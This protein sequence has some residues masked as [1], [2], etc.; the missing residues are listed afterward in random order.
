MAGLMERLVSPGA[1]RP[2]EGDRRPSR[3]VARERLRLVL[4]HDR[5]SLAPGLMPALRRDILEAVGRHL[6]VEEAACELELR[7][8]DDAVSLCA[9][10]PVRRVRRGG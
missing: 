10:I 8:D 2:R 3:D 9:T 4:L 5:A 7:R 1:A 6:E